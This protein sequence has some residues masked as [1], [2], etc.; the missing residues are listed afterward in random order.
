MLTG[1]FESLI[2]RNPLEDFGRWILGA[3]CPFRDQRLDGLRLRGV[4][5]WVF[6]RNRRLLIGQ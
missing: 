6:A 3:D 5:D 1:A 4:L 2:D